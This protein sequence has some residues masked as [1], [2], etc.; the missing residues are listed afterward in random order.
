[1]NYFK[2]NFLNI[3]LAVSISTQAFAVAKE[4]IERGDSDI[5]DSSCLNKEHTFPVD[6]YNGILANVVER[7]KDAVVILS[8]GPIR[9]KGDLICSGTLISNNAI[10]TAEHCR[11]TNVATFFYGEDNQVSYNVETYLETGKYTYLDYRIL[12]LNG[13]PSYEL[14][15]TPTPVQ[16]YIPTEDDTYMDDVILIQ[17]PHAGPMNGER[18]V[19]AGKYSHSTTRQFP[20]TGSGRNEK[21]KEE[22]QDM[23]QMRVLR[24]PRIV[25]GGGS[26]GSGLLD[27]FG[28][29]IGI[30][31]RTA[32]MDAHDA[33]CD[34]GDLFSAIADVALVSEFI[35]QYTLPVQIRFSGNSAN[36][37]LEANCSTISNIVPA[38]RN[39]ILE[40]GNGDNDWNEMKTT[41][42][43][44]S[45]APG[46]LVYANCTE[47]GNSEWIERKTVNGVDIQTLGKSYNLDPSYGAV[48]YPVFGLSKPFVVN[49]SITD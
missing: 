4:D 43:N 26:S 48:A 34:D 11:D 21:V 39:C 49:C 1:M 9:S 37:K 25:A 17:Q 6:D 7:R 47:S 32:L 42:C 22:Y 23:N 15:I 27:R 41:G 2:L 44:I 24:V 31:H 13:N 18:V 12:I 8:D 10:L 46:S 38:Y 14:G 33:L 3:F 29:L 36:S 20:T 35:R 28:N 45:C 30:T 5:A 19:V 16:A 40:N